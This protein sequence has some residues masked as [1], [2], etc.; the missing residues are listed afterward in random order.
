VPGTSKGAPTRFYGVAV[1]HNPGVYTEWTEAQEQI[2]DV[3]GPKYRKFDTRE[4]AEA[5]VKSGGKVEKV[6]KEVVG[7]NQGERERKKV[8]TATS[9]SGAKGSWLQVWT[10]GSSRGNGKKTAEAGVGVYFGYDDERYVAPI[11]LR[12]AN[13]IG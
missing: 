7:Q 13:A 10:D 9:K 6:E 2:T 1:G 3:K 12:L 5:F 11:F 4:E 8:K